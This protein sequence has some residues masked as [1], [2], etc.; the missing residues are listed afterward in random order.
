MPP[1]PPTIIGDPFYNTAPGLVLL[2]PDTPAYSIWPGPAGTTKIPIAGG[3]LVPAGVTSISYGGTISLSCGDVP[4]ATYQWKKGGTPILGATART[5]TKNNAVTS[6]SGVYSCVITRSP[7]VFEKSITITVG[8]AFTVTF[9]SQGGTSVA[10]K[11]VASGAM[12]TAPVPPTRAGYSF[13][14]WHKEAACVNPWNFSSDVVTGNVTLYAKWTTGPVNTVTFDS[15]GGSAVAAVNAIPGTAITAPAVPTR[16]GYAFAG[17]HKEAACINAWNFAT[18]TVT[19]DITLYAKWIAGG[20]ISPDIPNVPGAVDSISITGFPLTLA[21][22]ESFDAGLTYRTTNG[23]VPNPAPALNVTL[24]SEGASLV[25]IEVLSPVSARVTALPQAAVFRGAPANSAIYG[26]AIINFT[27]TQT[28]GGSTHQKTVSAPLVI[29]DGLATS[30]HLAPEVIDEFKG[31][32]AKLASSDETILPGNIQPPITS[33]DPD[34]YL[35]EGLDNALIDVINPDAYVLPVCFEPTGRDAAEIDINVSGLV[36]LG[37]KGLLPLTFRVTARRDDLADIFGAGLAEQMLASPMN[38]LDEIFTKMVIQKEIREGERNGWYTRL[39]NGI[40]KP[41]EAVEKGILE[42]AGGDALT[43]TLSYYVLDDSVLEAFEREGYLIVPD[44][45]HNGTIVDPIWLNMWRPD[46]APS[47]NSQGGYSAGS[48]G[49]C[50]S[51]DGAA[52]VL[53]AAFLAAAVFMKKTYNW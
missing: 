3:T 44:G 8:N 43:L 9:D 14:G 22:G 41:A 53:L 52:V 48:G 24:G 5:Y 31:A 1:T 35:I 47:D 16:P 19:A 50:T 40:L 4:G 49:G 23:A 29:A 2:V 51:W 7:A 28:L 17:W 11:T 46:Y 12:T 10:S 13:V 6:D 30:L 27:A 36:P 38:H 32:N 42:V 25:S 21:P 20:S 39:V 37:K 33:L 26:E 34:W 45:S 18:D 15:Q